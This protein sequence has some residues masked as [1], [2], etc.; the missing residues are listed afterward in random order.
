[1]IPTLICAS[2]C[3]LNVVLYV[4]TGQALNLGAAVFCGLLAIYCAILEAR[5]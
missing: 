3:A 1:M 2:L 5:S 4:T